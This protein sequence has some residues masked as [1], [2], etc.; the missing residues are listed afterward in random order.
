MTLLGLSAKDTHQLILMVTISTLIW[1]LVGFLLLCLM[2]FVSMQGF[3]KDSVHK[4]GVAEMESSRLGGATVIFGG[5]C[6]LIVLSFAGFRG[7]GSGPLSIDWFA[8][9]AIIGCSV[10]GLVEDIR[11]DSLSPRVRLAAKALIFGFILW[12]WPELI[13]GSIGVP[14]IDLLLSVP[15]LAFLLCLMFCVGFLNAVNMADG[16]NGLVSSIVV[17]TNIIFYKEIGE[18]GFLVVLISSS[19]FLIFNVIS[20]RLFLGDAGAYGIGASILVMTLWCYSEGHVSL[21]FLAV[22]LSY[23]CLDFAFSILRRFLTGQSITQPDNDHLHNRIHFQ[24]RKFFRSKNL[25][26]SSAGLTVSAASAGV[27]LWGYLAAWW[28]ITSGQWVMIFG[29]QCVAYLLVY[30][31]T[32]KSALERET[33]MSNLSV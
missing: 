27:A 5:V 2:Q 4:H 20:G 19:V 16:A 11:N 25:A 21:S 26:N 8:W 32:G 23:P 14:F 1:G 28:P 31:L 9:I 33:S 6:L 12:Q 7:A 3:A 22:L 29:A 15:V 13:P 10:L 18:L 30:Y 24:Y 17:I